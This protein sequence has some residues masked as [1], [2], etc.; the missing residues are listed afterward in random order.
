[1]RSID[2]QTQK[3]QNGFG[4]HERF[5]AV[6]IT[7]VTKSIEGEPIMGRKGDKKPS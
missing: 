3:N 7:K 2:Q 4:S 5:K 6:R 1:M